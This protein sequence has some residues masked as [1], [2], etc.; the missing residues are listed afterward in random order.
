[1]NNEQEKIVKEGIVIEILPNTK[2]RINLDSGE[3]IMGHLSGKMRIHYIKIIPGDRV[4]VE[5]SP[6]DNTKGRIVYRMK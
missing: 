3:E 2:F 6:Y 1:M 5:M 4:R